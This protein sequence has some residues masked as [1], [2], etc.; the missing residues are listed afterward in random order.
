MDINNFIDSYFESGLRVTKDELDYILEQLQLPENQSEYNQFLDGLLIERI[1]PKLIK[2]PYP[3][4]RK[5]IEIRDKYLKQY[6]ENI[7]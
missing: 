5:M 4:I 6:Y 7:I 1:T 3:K 2:I